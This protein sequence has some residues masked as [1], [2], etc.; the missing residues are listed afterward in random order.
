MTP[1]ATV[2]TAPDPNP[3]AGIDFPQLER[4]LRRPRTLVGVALD[5]MVTATTL[6]ALFPLF[7]VVWMLFWRGGKKLSLA[8]FTQLP[9]APLESGGGFGNAIVGS[10]FMVG[11]ATLITVPFGLLT[12]VYLSRDRSGRLATWVRFAAKV[13]TGFPSILAGVFAYGAVVLLTGGFSAVAG[14]IALS[15][16]MLPT[17]T[18]T[19]EDALRAVPPK[20]QEAALGMGATSAQVAFMVLLPTALPGILT[21]I[22]LAVARAA[23]ETAPLI[24]TALFS[25]YWLLNRGH[26]DAMHPT[27]SLAVLIYNFAGMPFQNQVELAWAAALVLVLMVL[28]ANLIGQSLSRRQ[29][30]S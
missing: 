15:I 11:L 27:A 25:N 9:P 22:M 4:S 8:L 1:D 14:A 20:M 19:S 16:L 10:L 21:G 12:A 24:F 26:L 29:I 28:G 6:L 17:V 2:A 5:V 23:G 30:V 13:L 18:L 3:F 7:S